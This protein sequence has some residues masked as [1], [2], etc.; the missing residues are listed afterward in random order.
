MIY[1]VVGNGQKALNECLVIGEDAIGEDAAAN[2]S[3]D[4]T[5]DG[6]SQRVNAVQK[7][8]KKMI[9]DYR[10]QYSEKNIQNGQKVMYLAPVSASSNKLHIIQ[11]IRGFESRLDTFSNLTKRRKKISIIKSPLGQMF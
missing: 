7:L 1:K 11:N 8:T 6:L 2:L 3:S 5:L 4:L 9:Q 10:K